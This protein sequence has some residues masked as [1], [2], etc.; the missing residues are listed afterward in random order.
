MV[1]MSE[2]VYELILD[3]IDEETLKELEE[4]LEEIKEECA[5]SQ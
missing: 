3:E 5:T 4:L 1:A 2:Y